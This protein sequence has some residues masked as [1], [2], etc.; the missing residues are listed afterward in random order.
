MN[1]RL[2]WLPAHANEL[3]HLSAKGRILWVA[4]DRGG[5]LT[6]DGCA[7][8]LPDSASIT[9]A[10]ADYDAGP[11]ARSGVAAAR[12]QMWDHGQMAASG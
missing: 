7:A 6:R 2:I 4:S 10:L 8:V 1:T 12:W 3:R 5:T 11:G 9:E